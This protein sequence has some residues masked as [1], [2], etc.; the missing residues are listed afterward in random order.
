VERADWTEGFAHPLRQDRAATG[1][2]VGHMEGIG[3]W[4]RAFR[5]AWRPEIISTTNAHEWT[6]RG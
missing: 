1:T 3:I 5:L 4:R 6:Q 2:S